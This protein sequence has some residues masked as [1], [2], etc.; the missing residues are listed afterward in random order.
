MIKLKNILKEIQ[1]DSNPKLEQGENYTIK[2]PEGDIAN[3]EFIGIS[4][5]GDYLFSTFKDGGRDSRP[6][7][8]YINPKDLKNYKIKKFK[9]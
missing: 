7:W 6:V 1:I 8:L 5:H 4:R 3:R 9:I 2:F